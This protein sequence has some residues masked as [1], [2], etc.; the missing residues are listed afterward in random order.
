M[1]PSGV[2]VRPL[3]FRV[4]FQGESVTWELC[5]SRRFEGAVLCDCG[6]SGTSCSR[7]PPQ[8][9]GGPLEVR[10]LLLQVLVVRSDGHKLVLVGWIKL[11]PWLR[12]VLFVPKGDV[13]PPRQSHQVQ[14]CSGHAE[15]EEDKLRDEPWMFLHLFTHRL[16]HLNNSS[17]S[18]RHKQ[19]NK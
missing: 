12:V 7:W 4:I 3:L 5:A 9:P 18:K 16:N 2:S 14:Q 15:G 8:S 11:V 19:T 6:D 1:I 10:A 13:G 17:Q